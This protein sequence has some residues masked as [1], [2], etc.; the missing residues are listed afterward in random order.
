MGRLPAKGR[1]LGILSTRL[2]LPAVVVMEPEVAFSEVGF[3]RVFARRIL[4]VPPLAV[5]LAVRAL[6]LLLGLVSP[7]LLVPPLAVMLRAVML[8][9]FVVKMLFVPPFALIVSTAMVRVSVAMS[10]LPPEL[11]IVVFSLVV[12]WIV[13]VLARRVLVA[14]SALVIEPLAVMV[15]L[16]FTSSLLWLSSL[17]EISPL[18]LICPLDSR[19]RVFTPVPLALISPEVMEPLVV[20]GFSVRL[21]LPAPPAMMLPA[22]MVSFV[23]RRVMLFVPP[24]AE[25]FSAAAM[26]PVAVGAMLFI[27]PLSAMM[28]PTFTSSSLVL[29]SFFP[30]FSAVMVVL[31]SLRVFLIVVLPLVVLRVL[32]LPEPLAMMEPFTPMVAP[33]SLRLRVFLPAS[34]AMISRLVSEVAGRLVAP[35][36]S[37]MVLLPLFA[38]MAWV[39]STRPPPVKLMLF[40]PPFVLMV[41]LVMLLLP[42]AVI[43]L[44]PESAAL[45][46]SDVTARVLVVSLFVPPLEVMEGAALFA[47]AWIVMEPLLARRVF[48][49]PVVEMVPCELMAAF[50]LSSVSVLFPLPALMPPA[51]RL[52]PAPTRVMAFV[53]LPAEMPLLAVIVPPAVVVMVLLAV[54][55][56]LMLSTFAS[57]SLELKVFLALSVAL[58]VWL[59]PVVSLMVILPLLAVKV[60]VP[61]PEAVI[62]PC[63][64]MAAPAVLSVRVLVPLL[65]EMSPLVREVFVPT[66]VMVFVPLLLAAMLLVKMEPPAVVEMMF[67]PIVAVMA[68]A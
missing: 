28:L 39:T 61:S 19:S 62:L 3:H 35:A 33:A 31:D 13:M 42:V 47:R 49:P 6:S 41:L 56:A 34:L 10:F 46:A 53:P 38:E 7:I 5:I 64:V 59:A 4:L 65:L 21:F 29:K 67:F 16:V 58:I 44:V 32:V 36:V 37:V 50:G 55:L 66:S 52:V 20:V 40:V 12:G 63:A 24:F 22:V 43:L 11:A 51:V 27:P 57:K 25:I 14:E 45:M 30:L 18:A 26:V 54:P 17:A 15:P 48:V 23:P 68:P 8:P 60:F 2:L 9:L 1:A